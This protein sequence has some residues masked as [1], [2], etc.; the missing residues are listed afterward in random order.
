MKGFPAPATHHPQSDHDARGV[1]VVQQDPTTAHVGQ[2]HTQLERRWYQLGCQLLVRM[3]S[4]DD[5]HG[6]DQES[7]QCTLSADESPV[8]CQPCKPISSASSPSHVTDIHLD[9]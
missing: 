5:C 1:I 4:E 8:P 9:L 3:Q 7:I 6:S 2:S